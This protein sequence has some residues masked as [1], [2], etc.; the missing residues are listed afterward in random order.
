MANSGPDTNGSQFFITYSKQPH[1]DHKNTVFGRYVGATYTDEMPVS[2]GLTAR[3]AGASVIDG[4][5]TLDFFE[6]TPVDERSRPLNP[7]RIRT[8]TI[9]A[10]PFAT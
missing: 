10:N 3:S 9:H 4:M 7:V 1:L 6:R 8:V 2:G 5:D